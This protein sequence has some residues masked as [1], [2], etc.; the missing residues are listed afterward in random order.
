MNDERA[1]IRTSSLT[2]A[3]DQRRVLDAVSFAVPSG[4]FIA[5]TGPNGSG[6]T[7]L[8][9]A[10]S[11]WLRP[12]RRTVFIG[13]RDIL[14]LT[15]KEAALS[16]A[17]V[18]QSAEPESAFSVWE[19]VLMGRAPHL[20]L[21]EQEHPADIAQ[22]EEALALTDLAALKERDISTLSGGEWKRVMIA[23]ALAQDADI[24]LLDEP[25]AHLD[26]AH[27]DGILRLLKRMQREKGLT[28]AAVLHDLNNASL[29]ADR[30]IL[31]G[32]GRI[33]AEGT[34]AEVITPENIR[35]VYGA[36]AIVIPHPENGRPCVLPR[37]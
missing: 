32:N 36:E 29:Y 6:K 8:L 16:L 14:T 27:G 20:G 37:G 15:R 22:A 1:D 31:L 7:T 33:E 3:F 17:H 19:T 26:L 5:V 10:L 35:R 11:G 2:F 34:P 25:T 12:S 4:G 9:R 28:V 30:I 21:L 24:L 13:G 23:Q 18:V